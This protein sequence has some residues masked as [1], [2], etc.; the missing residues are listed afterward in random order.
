MGGEAFIGGL[1][2]GSSGVGKE[3]GLNFEEGSGG[4][5]LKVPSNPPQCDLTW[6][7]SICWFSGATRVNDC[8][9]CAS[10]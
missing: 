7:A 4:D 5:R 10:L 2:T 1:W 3:N 9:C 8:E 6:H